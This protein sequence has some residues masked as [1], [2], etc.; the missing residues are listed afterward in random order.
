MFGK[1]VRWIY[2]AVEKFSD[3]ASQMRT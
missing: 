1:W 2:S 3:L